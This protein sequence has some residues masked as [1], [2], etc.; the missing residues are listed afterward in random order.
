[1]SV[2]DHQESIVW[3]ITNIHNSFVVIKNLIKCMENMWSKMTLNIII[4]GPSFFL[5]GLCI[6][7]LW[8]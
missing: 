3:W 5:W 1:M 8:K 6:C 2:Q 7:E 4:L